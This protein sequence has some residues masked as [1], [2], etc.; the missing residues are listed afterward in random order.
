MLTLK[1]IRI[2]WCTCWQLF[3]T[4]L[5]ILSTFFS[6]MIEQNTEAIS[7]VL[8]SLLEPWRLLTSALPSYEFFSDVP[9]QQLQINV[10]SLVHLYLVSPSYSQS[11]SS[12][13]CLGF[14]SAFPRFL[15]WVDH[16]H[17]PSPVPRAFICLLFQLLI[18]WTFLVFPQQQ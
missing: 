17:F 13:T 15:F 10:L 16:I 18:L 4:S 6:F 9:L 1:C 8:V 5:Q 12:L 14:L 7:R 2:V 3:H 11:F